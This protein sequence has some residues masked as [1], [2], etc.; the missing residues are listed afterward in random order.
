MA[1]ELICKLC[2]QIVVTIN[3]YH[4]STFHIPNSKLLQKRER[5]FVRSLAF[6]LLLPAAVIPACDLEGAADLRVEVGGLVVDAAVVP[7]GGL[8]LSGSHEEDLRL[9]GAGEGE[10]IPVEVVAIDRDGNKDMVF[11]YTEGE[12]DVFY[13]ASVE[14]QGLITIVGEDVPPSQGPSY[15]DLMKNVLWGDVNDNG[16]VSAT[17]LVAMV[18]FMVDPE[19]AGVTEQGLVNGNL[20]QGDK[21]LD[22][23]SDEIMNAYDLFLLKKYILEDV[24]E[25]DFPIMD[26][27]TVK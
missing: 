3:L 21:N 10:K 1:R 14:Q 2:P 23:K 11:G 9:E 4:N 25:E 12:K 7:R 13:T 16:A 24:A 6:D 26:M 5:T 22:L 8:A 27:K 18:K 15:D 20:Y 19:T 17:D